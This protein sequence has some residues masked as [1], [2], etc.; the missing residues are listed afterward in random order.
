MTNAEPDS[1][2]VLLFEVLTPMGFS[3]RCTR[4]YWLAK[5]V[6]DHPIMA[7]RDQEVK[8]ALAEP[9]EV[10]QSAHDTG[11]MLF[12]RMGEKRLVCVVVR[13][14]NGDGFLITAYPTDVMKK[15]EKRWPV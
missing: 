7:G 13:H 3:V 4:E 8:A 2:N 15:G 9:I 6:G 14:L 12:Y 11:V 5:V 1:A 10:R